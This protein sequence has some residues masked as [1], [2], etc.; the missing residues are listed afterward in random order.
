MSH[1]RSNA[2]V[3]FYPNKLCVVDCATSVAH[4][5]LRVELVA[6]ALK[7]FLGIF[8]VGEQFVL[9]RVKDRLLAL[10]YK[11]L[12]LFLHLWPLFH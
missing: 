3:A 5:R 9:K 7:L 1:S 11:L 12:K 2:L 4:K 6:V 8:L 10:F